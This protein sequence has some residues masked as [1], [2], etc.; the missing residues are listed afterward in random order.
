MDSI[1]EE[2]VCK[3]VGGHY[4]VGK[5]FCTPCTV[6]KIM[7]NCDLDRNQSHFLDVHEPHD[8]SEER[9]DSNSNS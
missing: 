5:A 4:D 1:I 6:T 3:I 2:M 9:A 8:S 7:Q